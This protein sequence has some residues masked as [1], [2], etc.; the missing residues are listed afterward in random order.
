MSWWLMCLLNQSGGQTLEGGSVV[1]QG[2]TGWV[3]FCAHISPWQTIPLHRH[4]CN[5]DSEKWDAHTDSVSLSLS[6]SLSHL[7]I[8]FFTFNSR[9]MVPTTFQK[10]KRK[11]EKPT[12]TATLTPLPLPRTYPLLVFPV[13]TWNIIQTQYSI[14]WTHF[15]Q[16]FVNHLTAMRQRSGN[17]TYTETWCI[18]TKKSWQLQSSLLW[19]NWGLCPSPLCLGQPKRFFFTEEQHGS[20]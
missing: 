18:Q 15:W 17:N 9:N 19:D 16:I 4:C 1:G 12:L 5:D 11:D 20:Q 7:F 14:V 2:E 6:L 10:H 13:R 8:Y 3:W